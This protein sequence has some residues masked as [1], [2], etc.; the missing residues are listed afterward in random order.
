LGNI[1]SI[2]LKKGG[3]HKISNKKEPEK[4]KVGKPKDRKPMDGSQR[5]K[6]DRLLGGLDIL[7]MV[8]LKPVTS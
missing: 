7:G 2:F 3:C 8:G 4:E 1:G 5:G 6:K